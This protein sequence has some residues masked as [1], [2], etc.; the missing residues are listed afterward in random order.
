VFVMYWRIMLEERWVDIQIDRYTK[1]DYLHVATLMGRTVAVSWLWVEESTTTAERT[2][3]EIRYFIGLVDSHAVVP[4]R[5]S[6]G[7]RLMT[8]EREHNKYAFIKTTCHRSPVS[9][10]VRLSGSW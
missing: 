3:V 1:N 4:C 8:A 7:I 5:L 10:P 6:S 2:V 9:S